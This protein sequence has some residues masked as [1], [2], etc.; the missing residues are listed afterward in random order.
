M[1]ASANKKQVAIVTGASS[2]IGLGITGRCSNLATVSSRIPS[3]DLVLV[4]GDLLIN[5]AG[6]YIARSFTEN[7]RNHN[8]YD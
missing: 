1:G 4:D 5:G 2:G 8:H 6:I 7:A 3:A